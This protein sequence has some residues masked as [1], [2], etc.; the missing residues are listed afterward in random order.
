MCVPFQS[1]TCDCRTPCSCGEMLTVEEE[2]QKMEVMR[3]HLQ[4][5]LE[6]IERRM[7]GLKN[8]RG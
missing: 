1:Q 4:F 6:L 3:K 7:S 2:I 5:Q 8:V